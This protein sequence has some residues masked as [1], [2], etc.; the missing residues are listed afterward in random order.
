M[1]TLKK[2]RLPLRKVILL[3]KRAI[4]VEHVQNNRTV[5]SMLGARGIKPEEL[6][7]AED[8]KKVERRVARE[9]KQLEHNTQK[10]PRNNNK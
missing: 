6:P 1:V 5:R 10:L 4:T 8:I 2:K 9:E 7:A 3:F